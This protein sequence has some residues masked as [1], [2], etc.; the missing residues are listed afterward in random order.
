MFIFCK[1][2][3]KKI[4]YRTKKV[5]CLFIIYNYQQESDLDGP[6]LLLLVALDPPLLPASSALTL[7]STKALTSTLTLNLKLILTL[8]LIIAFDRLK[9]FNGEQT[10][11]KFFKLMKTQGGGEV[12]SF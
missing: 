8:S 2:K 4:K 9:I 7:T 10:V 1:S 6:E 3:G 12:I 11:G 5:M